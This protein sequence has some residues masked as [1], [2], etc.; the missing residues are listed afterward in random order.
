MCKSQKG[1]IHHSK[2][3]P[4]L[5][6]RNNHLATDPSTRVKHSIVESLDMTRRIHTHS[7]PEDIYVVLV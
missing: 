6:E 2:R 4:L 3:L 1:Y 5:R 7:F